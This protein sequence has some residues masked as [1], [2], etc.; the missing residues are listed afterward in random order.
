MIDAKI[1]ANSGPMVFKRIITVNEPNPAPIRSDAY[2][3]LASL[4]RTE[5]AVAI[6]NPEKKKG[7]LRTKQYR[8]K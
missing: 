7:V 3:E 5:N 1:I 6:N 2:I 8:A 4:L